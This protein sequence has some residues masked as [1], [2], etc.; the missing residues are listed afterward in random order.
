MKNK[1]F[2]KDYEKLA[3]E[4]GQ[5]LLTKLRQHSVDYG[6]LDYW[7]ADTDMK[8]GLVSMVESAKLSR[9]KEIEIN[10]MKTSIPDT[11]LSTLKENLK[12]Y[13]ELTLLSKQRKYALI[14][15]FLEQKEQNTEDFF[16]NTIKIKNKYK[17]E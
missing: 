14:V 2:V 9:Y 16:T 15:K 17:N 10:F 1:A 13:G 12:R 8:K 3:E 7:V 5:N 4:F 6:F 11:E